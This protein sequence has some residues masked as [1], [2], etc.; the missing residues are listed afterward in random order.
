MNS[1][2][3]ECVCDNGGELVDGE[4][5]CTGNKVMNSDTNTCEPCPSGTTASDGVCVCDNGGELIDGECQ[6]CPEDYSTSS[7]STCYVQTTGAND[8]ACYQGVECCSDGYKYISESQITSYCSEFSQGLLL[9]TCRNK[10]KGKRGSE[11]NGDQG[12]I[13]VESK[14]FPGSGGGTITGCIGSYVLV[15]GEC[16]PCSDGEIAVNN[17]CVGCGENQVVV[18]NKCVDY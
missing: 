15:N 3:T 1:A 18:N 7:N 5:V 14:D 9:T 2:G 4:C 16:Q 11:A 10:L 12:G 13:C 17:K 6:V 8:V